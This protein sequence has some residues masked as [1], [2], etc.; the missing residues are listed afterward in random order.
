M[1][2]SEQQADISLRT[3]G[4]YRPTA[5]D[6][7]G[8]GLDDRQAWLV[9]PCGLN[10][11]SGV[12]GESNWHAQLASLGGESD[13]LEIHRFGHW[14]CGWLEIVIVHPSRADEVE[15]IAN[16]LADYPILD[17]NDLGEREMLAADEAWDQSEIKEQALHVATVF[18]LHSATFDWL[19]EHGGEMLRQMQNEY[20]DWSYETQEDGVCFNRAW[21]RTRRLSRADLAEMI[22]RT[23]ADARKAARS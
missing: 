12:C 16:A 11:D 8:L 5:C 23:R 18:D 10:R 6:T 13:T 2:K 9:A 14:A 20:S 15:E 21:A 3:Y 17:D 1:S 19:R 7:A 22:R 4:Q